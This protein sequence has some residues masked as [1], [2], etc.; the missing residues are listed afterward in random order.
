M[1]RNGVEEDVL[2]KEE[3]LD[4]S[5]RD[6]SLPPSS[7]SPGETPS[8][9][10]P[11]GDESRTSTTPPANSKPKGKA[12][13]KE[14]QLIGDLPRAEEAAM[15]TFTQILENNYQYG[16]LGRSREA[17]ESMTCD[18]QYEHG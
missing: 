15:Q 5:M 14:P 13:K 9:S 8:A 12:A 3:E 4:S 16:T 18:C 17:L 1:D 2:M 10:P 7:A 11:A 6:D